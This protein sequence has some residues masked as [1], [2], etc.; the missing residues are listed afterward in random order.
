MLPLTAFVK[1][2]G[3]MTRVSDESVQ[4]RIAGSELLGN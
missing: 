2:C 4:L 1:D 3:L